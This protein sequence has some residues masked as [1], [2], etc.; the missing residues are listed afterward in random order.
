[1]R[2]SCV[3]TGSQTARVTLTDF[4]STATPTCRL[5]SIDFVQQFSLHYFFNKNHPVALI[6]SI[7]AVLFFLAREVHLSFAVS[8]KLYFTLILGGCDELGSN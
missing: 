1:M 3:T 2:I 4:A 7:S 6:V 5:A 8:G